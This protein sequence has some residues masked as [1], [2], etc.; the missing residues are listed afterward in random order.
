MDASAVRQ[1]AA[2]EFVFR[3]GD[4]GD[5]MYILLE[6]AVELKMKVDRGETVLKT[7]DQANEFFGEMALIDGRPRSAS[8]IAA[9]PSKLMAVDGPT[10]ESLILSNGKFALK[11][12]KILAERIRR[13][14]DR[15]EELIETTPKERVRYGM[16][17]FAHKGGER[18][19]DG[20]FKVQVEDMRA[21]I[22]GRLGI[23]F[24]EIDACLFKLVKG[25]SVAYAATSA[26]TREHLLLSPRFVEENDR[27]KQG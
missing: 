10:F 18:I 12:I 15:V 11:I 26:K 2:G 20:S 9:L 14:N 4:A 6:G 21:W 24:D 16:S 7:I 19:H 17:D 5:R 8:A 23:P 3:E 27:R 13:S 25:G 1:I 22:N